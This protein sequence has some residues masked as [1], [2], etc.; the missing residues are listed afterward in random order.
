MPRPSIFP[1][2]RHRLARPGKPS[3]RPGIVLLLALSTLGAGC[4]TKGPSP[5]AIRAQAAFPLQATSLQ[6]A[7]YVPAPSPVP[8]ADS[9]GVTKPWMEEQLRKFDHRYAQAAAD[10][11]AIFEQSV[12]AMKSAVTPADLKPLTAGIG[13]VGADLTALSGRFESMVSGLQ[14][15]IRELE[16]TLSDAKAVAAPAVPAGPTASVPGPDADSREFTEALRALQA[17]P[18]Q[19]LPLRAWYE[20][21]ATDPKAPEALFQLGLAFLDSGYPTAGKLYLRRLLEEHGASTQAREAKA[22]LGSTPAPKP[23]RPAPPKPEASSSPAVN[24]V[25]RPDCGPK[26]VCA[27]GPAARVPAAAK[28]ETPAAASPTAPMPVPTPPAKDAKEKAA[29]GPVLAPDTAHA[30]TAVPTGLVPRPAAAPEPAEMA[31]S[32]MPPAMRLK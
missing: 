17:T 29:A 18:R 28:P 4:A 25:E 11:K 6:P 26:V 8:P 15:R 19:T 20:G 27:P 31:P 14:I 21:H 24:Q 32:I 30:A 1:L 23:K 5:E 16:R 13:K 22:L 2:H 9:A 7:P 3:I 10:I 12:A